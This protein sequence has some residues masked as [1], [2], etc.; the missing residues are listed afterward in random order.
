ML[1]MKK[2]VIIFLSGYDLESVLIKYMIPYVLLFIFFY[3]PNSEQFVDDNI[4]E[5]IRPYWS[6][7]YNTTSNPNPKITNSINSSKPIEINRF[8]KKKKIYEKVQ[9][10]EL[11]IVTWVK[12][13]I[14]KTKGSSLNC[15][16]YSHFLYYK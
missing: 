2:N 12:D 8:H 10:F 7:N 14:S 6:T 1:K 11:W 13:L 4:F 9:T 15:C 16:L 5:L 3:I